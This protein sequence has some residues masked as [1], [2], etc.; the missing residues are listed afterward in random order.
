MG[1][2]EVRG[3]GVGCEEHSKAGVDYTSL[4]LVSIS[5]RFCIS[6][7]GLKNIS[8]KEL[9]RVKQHCTYNHV[10]PIQ[11]TEGIRP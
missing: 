7:V 10:N 1:L 2:Q 8:L 9:V 4:N 3:F 11:A 6:V 5:E